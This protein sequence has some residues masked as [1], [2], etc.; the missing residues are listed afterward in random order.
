MESILAEKMN[1]KESSNY[2]HKSATHYN[3]NLN[4]NMKENKDQIIKN[5]FED[6]KSVV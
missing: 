3:L 6:R 5:E 1:L 4:L 2:H